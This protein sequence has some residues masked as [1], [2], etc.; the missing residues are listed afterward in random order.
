MQSRQGV[1]HEHEMRGA[2][3]DHNANIGGTGS[4]SAVMRQYCTQEEIDIADY[5]LVAKFSRL[6]YIAKGKSE[7]MRGINIID[8]YYPLLF[9]Q[10]KIFAVSKG[11]S[12][13]NLMGLIVDGAFDIHS[14]IFPKQT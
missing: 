1:E 9:K 11:L 3:T 2:H 8:D 4:I 7:Y 10:L 14:D 12:V 5:T 13:I 6:A